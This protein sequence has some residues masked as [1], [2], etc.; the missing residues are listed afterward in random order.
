MQTMRAEGL[1][2]TYG[3][4]TLFKDVNFIINENDRIGLIGVNGSGKTSLLNVISGETSPEKGTITKP[5]DYTIGY[6]KQQPELDEGKTIMEAIFEGQQPVFKTIR[7]YEDALKKF[8]DHPEDPQAIDRYTKMQAKMDQEDAWEADS[9]VKT[10]LTQLKIKDTSQK[11]AELSGGQQKRV[12][13]AQV[14]IEQPD[15]LLL[16]EPT[17]HL[18]LDS[19]IWLQDFLKS[20]KGAV[21][22]VTHDRYFLDQV[23]NHIW[24]LSFG[25]LYHYEG[26]YQDFV[27]KK[28]ERV[29]LAQETEKK[30]QQLYKKELAWMRT[31]AKARSTKQKGRINRF[32]ELEGKVGNLKVDQ[33]ISI[34]LGS[35]RL[36]KDVIKFENANLQLG[37]HRILKDFNWLVQAGDRIGITGENGAGKTS[38]LNVIAQRVPLDSGVLK[39][40]ETVKLGYYTQQTEGVDDS[41]RMISFLSEIAENVTDKDGNKISVTQL[42]ERFLFPRFMH[43][44]LIRKLS[45]GEKRRLY[46]LKILMQQPN[47]LLLDEPTNDLDIG[48]LTVLEDYLDNFAGT[49]ITVS[50]DRYFLDKVADDLLIFHGNGQIQRYTGRFTD[51]LKE[52]QAAKDSQQAAKETVKKAKPAP[53][54]KPAAKMKTKLTYAEQLEWNHIDDDLDQLDQKHQDLEKR[55]AAAASDYTKLADLQKQLNEVQKQIDEKTARWEY[56][57]NFVDE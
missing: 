38:L 52:Q 8:S 4:K 33:D 53:K 2:S 46:L 10:I 48:T 7:A 29:E 1:T 43:G 26:N 28:A 32:H 27:A 14:L 45:G 57:S 49:V 21:L 50:H 23:T 18:D 36:G 9:Q 6:L 5:N 34:N 35:Q 39:I 19:V 51:Y 31:G 17:N 37:D 47:V 40:G 30:N 3:E 12:G 16:D 41:K 56:L 54:E 24:E 22:V 11:I 42:L 25:N 15:L 20:Y 13:L 55:M 44:T